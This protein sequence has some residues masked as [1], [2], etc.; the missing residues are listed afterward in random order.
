MHTL[1]PDSRDCSACGGRLEATDQVI[2]AGEEIT[3]VERE[4]KLVRYQRRLYRCGCNDKGELAPAPVKLSPRARYSLAFAIN[5]AIDKYLH[6]MPLARQVREMKTQGLTMDTQTLWDQLRT[7]AEH[8]KPCYELIR[9]YIL[10]ADVIAADETWWRLMKKASS[11]KW[12]VWAMSTHDAV[13]YHADE[14]RNTEAARRCIGNFN[15]IVLCDGYAVY[16]S[17]AKTNSELLLAYCWSHARRKFFE[18]R[19]AYP[20]E[21]DV[22]LDLIDELFAIERKAPAPDA[23]EGDAK[24]D[25]LALRTQLRDRESRSIVAKLHQWAHEQSALPEGGLRKAIQYMLNQWSGLT[26]FLDNPMI[27]LHNN[28]MEQELRNWVLGRKNHY[29]SR[30]QRG[31]EVAALFYTLIETA[32]LCDVDPGEY[33]LR[34]ATAAIEHPAS[35]TLPHEMLPSP[36]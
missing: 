6:H 4:Y 33:L 17:L 7:L 23:L 21:C 36:R 28:H 32:R 12:W 19:D 29:G 18:A 13:F 14:R 10:G 11:R 35:A 3:V 9:H 22:A 16:G 20:D 26:R 31:T 5:V 24:S 34:A 2:E 27:P 30:S 25:A 15:G 1:D 8:L